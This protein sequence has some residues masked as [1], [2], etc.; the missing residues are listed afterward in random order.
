MEPEFFVAGET[1]TRSDVGDLIGY[2]L[3]HRSG[4]NFTTGYFEFQDT[5]YVFA[6]VGMPGRTGHDY[7]NRWVDAD[8]VWYGKSRSKLGQPQ[9]EKMIGG[10]YPVHLFWRGADRAKFT[11]AG[12]AKAIEAMDSQPVEIVWAFDHF[13]R[14]LQ[15]DGP[16]P[17]SSQVWRRGPAPTSGERQT[18]LS[19]SPTS[20]YLM[21]LVGASSEVHPQLNE[22]RAII[23]IGISV[24]PRR[25]LRELNS[26]YPPGLVLSWNLMDV[27]EFSNG[28]TAFANE[29]RVLEAL[30][31]LG[32]WIGGEFGVVEKTELQKVLS[33]K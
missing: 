23:K 15:K 33:Y 6:N 18:V 13:S 28:Q 31:R 20:L 3:V 32:N 2:P 27:A 17:K 12:L 7:P 25:R 30:R 8:L 14:S 1:Y 10:F 24:D 29:G 22:N 16:S 9:I 26:G 21:T 5:F 4:G 19:D 11:Y